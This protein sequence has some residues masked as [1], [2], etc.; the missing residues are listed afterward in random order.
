MRYVETTSTFLCDSDD[1]VNQLSETKMSLEY[2]RERMRPG[3]ST[4]RDMVVCAQ[5]E[6]GDWMRDAL[7]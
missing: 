7:W 6:G 3:L 4:G 2:R 5:V 1:D